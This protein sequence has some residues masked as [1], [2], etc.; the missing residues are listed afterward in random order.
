MH[1]APPSTHEPLSNRRAQAIFRAWRYGQTRRVFVYRLIGHGTIQG[2]TDSACTLHSYLCTPSNRIL[3]TVCGAGTIEEKIYA[4]Q[5]AK[6][7]VTSGVCDDEQVD[8]THDQ[9]L[10]NQGLPHPTL[11]SHCSPAF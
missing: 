10:P 1:T 4:R 9:G 8:T 6:A 11:R 3:S 5:V 7:S 2:L